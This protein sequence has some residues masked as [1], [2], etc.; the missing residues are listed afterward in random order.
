MSLQ[1]IDIIIVIFYMVGVLVFG[2]WIGRR[3]NEDR[4]GFFLGGRS[5]SW[6]LI[7][8]SLFATNISSVQFVGQSG[9]AYEIGIA[10]ANPQLI[11][12]IC[13]MLSAVFFIPIYLRTKIFTIPGFLE[14]RYN[15]SSKLI[16]CITMT[17]FG[18]FMTSIIL[19]TGSLVILQLFG[20]D[21]S[22]IFLCALVLGIAV[23]VYAIVGGLSSVVYTDLVQSIVL[24][25]GGF[26]VL[27][28]GLNAVGG[29]SGLLETVPA[30]HF[31]LML[32][33]DHPQMPFTGVM[34]GVFF[35]SLFWAVSNQ[36]LLQRTLGAK[37][38]RNAQLGMLLGGFL[39]LIAI[40]VLVFPGIL[41]F[42]LIPGINPDRA[43]PALIQQI[44]PIG[45]SGIVLAGFLAALMSTLD[46]SIMSLSSIF[47]IDI[48]P[49]FKK[50]V[51]EERALKVGRI[52]AISI[53]VWGIITAPVIQHLGLVYLLMHKVSSYLLPSIGVCYVIGRFSKR[54]NGFGAIVT[55]GLG[56]TIGTVI[57]LISTL[58]SLKPYC[59]DIILNNHFYH[60][61]FFLVLSYITILLVSSRFRPAPKTEEL[62]FMKTTQEEKDDQAATLERVGLLGSFKFWS[63]VYLCGFVGLYWLF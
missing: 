13:L 20:F 54:V 25:I 52:A 31:E 48:Y 3:A 36:E 44:L 30:D 38:T 49:L 35:I 45:I 6:I 18:L 47:A 27:F 34:T 22:K 10:A 12:G 32:P 58:P 8:T 28:L 21:E 50:E 41:A 7:G 33:S 62:A 46:S 37:D 5:F 56:F 16:Y 51:T 15:K 14:T 57:L 63:L 61:N 43:Y 40:F 59:P 55:L 2:I 17:V 29:V 19:Y 42:K 26:L 39:K 24:L 23:G 1:L 11:G 60:V 9:L 4:E 53:L